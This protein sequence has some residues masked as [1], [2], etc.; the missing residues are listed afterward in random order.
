MTTPNQT[1]QGLGTSSASE[2]KEYFANLDSHRKQFVWEGARRHGCR[3]EMP[4]LGKRGS[5]QRRK[6]RAGAQRD[7]TLLPCTHNHHHHHPQQ[8]TNTKQN[9]Q[10]TQTQT[11]KPQAGRT[12]TRSRWPSP[13]SASRTASAGCRGTSPARSSTRAPTRSA[14]PTLCTRSARRRPAVVV[15][16][17]CA[18]LMRCLCLDCVL[19]ALLRTGENS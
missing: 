12:P 14:T 10:N 16:V 6:S 2:A 9:T 17:L 4:D 11:N 19:R 15:W 7:P 1:K 5:S 3:F 18:A 13:R 8:Q